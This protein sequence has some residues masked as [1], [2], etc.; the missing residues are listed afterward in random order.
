MK[1]T[2]TFL[3]LFP[4]ILALIATHSVAQNIFLTGNNLVSAMREYDK[5]QANVASVNGL[6]AAEYMA[7]VIGVFD[8]TTSSYNLPA[9]ATTGQ[10]IAVVSK[11]LKEHPEDWSKPAADLVV[12]AL[13]EAFPKT[14]K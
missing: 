2:I 14:S 12:K 8:A 1:R 4:M 6:Q 11:Y 7:Y 9:Q 5:E 3:I 10:V 13:A